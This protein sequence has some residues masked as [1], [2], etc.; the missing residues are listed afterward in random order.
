[1]NESQ[2]TYSLSFAVPSASTLPEAWGDLTDFTLHGMQ[3][4]GF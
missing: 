4:Q 3:G 2:Y 1:M